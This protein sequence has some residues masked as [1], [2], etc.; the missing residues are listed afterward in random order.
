MQCQNARVNT[1]LDNYIFRHFVK[2]GKSQELV[3][4]KGRF[5]KFLFSTFVHK[6]YHYRPFIRFLKFSTRPC[7][8][9]TKLFSIA[10]LTLRTNRLERS[11]LAS[12]ARA[13]LKAGYDLTRVRLCCKVAR[14][15]R[16]LSL[17][18]PYSQWRSKAI[19]PL[20]KFSAITPAISPSLPS[21]PWPPLEA[22]AQIRSFL[23]ELFVVKNENNVV[24]ITT[25][26]LS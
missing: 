21:L 19:F 24:W 16:T 22:T 25:S 3:K 23:I 26:T 6:T 9:V 2:N 20:A 14:W 17:I 8:N 5:Y 4:I 15:G 11:S 7:V 1:T 10:S 18:C 12:K 13:H